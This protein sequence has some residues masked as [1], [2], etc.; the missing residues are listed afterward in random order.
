MNCGACPDP[1]ICSDHGC[2]Q[3]AWEYEYLQQQAQQ[4]QWTPEDEC[5]SRGHPYCG[6]DQGRGRCY[7]GAVLYPPGGQRLCPECKR[8]HTRRGALCLRCDTVAMDSAR[9]GRHRL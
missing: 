4:Q 7:C 3:E 5:T 8:T 1:S 2:Q 9:L 6:D